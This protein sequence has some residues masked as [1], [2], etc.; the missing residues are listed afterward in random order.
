[1][2]LQALGVRKDVS[3]SLEFAEVQCYEYKYFKIDMPP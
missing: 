3:L 2:K 1:M